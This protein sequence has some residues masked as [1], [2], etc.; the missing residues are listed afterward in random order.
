[1]L[2]IQAEQ[3]YLDIIMFGGWK[4]MVKEKFYEIEFL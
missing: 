3:K 4:K 1:M 2:E